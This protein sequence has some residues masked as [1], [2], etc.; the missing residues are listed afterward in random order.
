MVASIPE[1]AS[2]IS[3]DAGNGRAPPDFHVDKPVANIDHTG[4]S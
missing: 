4:G 1:L 3:R 2:R